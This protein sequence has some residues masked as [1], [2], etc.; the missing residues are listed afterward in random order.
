[1]KSFLLGMLGFLAVSSIGHSAIDVYLDRAEIH[2]PQIGDM[3]LIRTA[4]TPK[5]VKIHKS[6]DYYENVCVARDY[7]STCGRDRFRC[8]T[9]RVVRQVWDSSAQ[10]YVQ[11]V[12]HRPRHC[13]W[14]ESFCAR[15]QTQLRRG[16]SKIKLEFKKAPAVPFN[17]EDVFLITETPR[18]GEPKWRM[19]VIQSSSPIKIDSGRG[20]LLNLG[21]NK[22]KVKPL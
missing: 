17:Q 1:M 20:G 22:F 14:E 3:R 11:R 8:G 19:S 15:T 18:H 4:N 5:K 2:V 16:N 6:Y 21:S 12:R 9:R 10:R 13:C 7:R